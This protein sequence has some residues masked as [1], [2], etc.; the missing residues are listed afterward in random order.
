MNMKR[1]P[2]EEASPPQLREFASNVLGIE[3]ITQSHNSTQMRAKIET[4][5]PGLKFIIVND[6][7]PPAGPPPAVEAQPPAAAPTM[8]LGEIVGA[9]DLAEQER[10][11]NADPENR[12]PDGT[13]VPFS[14][15]PLPPLHKASHHH[16]PTIEINIPSTRERG[17]NRDV[18]VAV[19]GT[20][21]LIQRDKWV[22]VPYRVFGALNDAVE[23][24]LERRQDR[25]NEKAEIVERESLAYQFSSRNPP[26]E[27][28][29]ADWHAR[30]DNCF[31]G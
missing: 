5:E 15:R 26:T 3:G 27:A 28:E 12:Y 4:V 8:P 20:P 6:E 11:W 2:I 16:D 10:R 31:A 17:G 22:K 24:H 30:T 19:D 13:R 23:K 7:P 18:F 21:F 29:I 14:R 1:I 25:T 9:V